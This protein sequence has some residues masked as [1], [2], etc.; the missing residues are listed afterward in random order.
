MEYKDALNYINNLD[1]LGIKLGLERMESILQFLGNPHTRFRAIHITG[2]NG[3]GSTAA[4]INSI[5]I[6]H[7]FRVGLFTSPYLEKFTESIK[8]NGTEIKEGR[9]VDFVKKVKPV[10]KVLTRR[11]LGDM[12]KFELITAMAFDYFASMKIDLAVVEVGLGGRLD[13]TNVLKDKVCVITPISLDHRDVLGETLEEIAREKAGIIK[14]GNPVVSGK[15]SLTVK[16]VLKEKV[17]KSKTRIFFQSKDFS[18]RRLSFNS[19][20]GQVFDYSGLNINLQKLEIS[21]S[22]LHQVE[23]AALALAAVECLAEKNK[24]IVRKKAIRDGLKHTRWP[25]RF[26][27][28]L[29]NPRVVLDGAHNPHGAR[30]LR[31]TLE[32]QEFNRL[33]LVIGML[34]DKDY[35]KFVDIIAPV[36]DIAIVTKPSNKRALGTEIL[37]KEFQNHDI[38]TETRESI[39][40]AVNRALQISREGDLICITGSLYL[41]GEVRKE[42]LSNK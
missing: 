20:S 5:L 34:K 40:E 7:G 11:G 24:F 26:E 33:I 14:E 8:V 38:V 32:E 18:Y 10:T 25:G 13:S 23:N 31:K 27:V 3:K 41:I 16:R 36:T 1:R 17:K 30:V 2:T 22:G 35:S 29:N 15:Q 37:K 39:F 12:T 42:F 21:M 9:V 28:V 4:F 19:S 6:H